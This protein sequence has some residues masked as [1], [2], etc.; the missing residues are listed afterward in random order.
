[1]N[2]WNVWLR[3]SKDGGHTW[4][5]GQRIS[6]FM[7]TE[8]QSGPN[9]FLFPYGDYMRVE[10]NPSCG[11]APVMVWGEGQNWV[12]GAAAPGHINY[13]SLC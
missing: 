5:A 10:L 11:D 7:P 12:G 13:R 6:A 3:A 4:T 1:M 2:G 8:A 9:G